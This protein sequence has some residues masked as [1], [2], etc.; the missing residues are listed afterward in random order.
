MEQLGGLAEVKPSSEGTAV[1]LCYKLVLLELLS[2]PIQGAIGGSS[3][4]PADEAERKEVLRT[5]G[6]ARLDSDLLADLLGQRGH[7]NLID[8]KVM[9][10][11]VSQGAIGVP[12]LGQR[13][14]VE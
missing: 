8:V 10:G 2:D 11:A 3:E 9:K 6:V 1:R 7:R 4:E 12:R 13:A 5:L 14:L